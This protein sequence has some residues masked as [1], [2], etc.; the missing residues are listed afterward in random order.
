MTTFSQ[1][2]HTI[3]V[4]ADLFSMISEVPLCHNGFWFCF[5]FGTQSLYQI[6]IDQRKNFD[7]FELKVTVATLKCFGQK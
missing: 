4:I 5:S 1:C 3:L 7:A 6:K 2:R